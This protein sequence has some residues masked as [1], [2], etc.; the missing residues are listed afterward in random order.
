[1]G[2]I[3]RTFLH[4]SYEEFR[5]WDLLYCLK[6]QKS[7]GSFDR[8]G[9]VNVSE[10]FYPQIRR[11]MLSPGDIIILLEWYPPRTKQNWSRSGWKAYLAASPRRHNQQMSLP[12][13]ISQ[14]RPIVPGRIFAERKQRWTALNGANYPSLEVIDSLLI[15]LNS[16]SPRVS[17]LIL[18]N[19]H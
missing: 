1:M 11:D 5:K 4:C 7:P 3:S 12:L 6:L 13:K 10:V 9:E 14:E 16:H 18:Q 17:S 8:R 15:L 19:L 2:V